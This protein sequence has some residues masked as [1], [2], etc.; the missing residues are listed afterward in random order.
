MLPRGGMGGKSRDG[1]TIPDG[2]RGFRRVAH[3]SATS[4]LRVSPAGVLFCRGRL[5]RV[6][7]ARARP[8]NTAINWTKGENNADAVLSRVLSLFHLIL[9][10]HAPNHC[11]RSP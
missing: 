2:T 7:R 5:S 3:D 4:L 6:E 1:T 10:N 9:R 11:I 8:T